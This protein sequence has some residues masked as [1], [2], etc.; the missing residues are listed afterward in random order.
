MRATFPDSL[1]KKVLWGEI[2]AVGT[3]V[4]F[5]MFN[6]NPQLEEAGSDKL[7]MMYLALALSSAIQDPLFSNASKL[8]V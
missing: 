3:D 2:E 6:Q 7:S 5:K 4:W 1:P 8:N